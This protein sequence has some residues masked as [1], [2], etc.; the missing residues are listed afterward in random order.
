[1]KSIYNCL[2]LF[3]IADVMTDTNWDLLR[4]QKLVL[5]KACEL[6]P[7]LEGIL[8]WIDA[9]QDAAEEDGFPVVFLTEQELAEVAE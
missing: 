8:N 5:V 3:N 4:E 1:M 6:Y 2:D 9:L 7:A